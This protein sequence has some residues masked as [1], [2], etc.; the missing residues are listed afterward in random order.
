M[1]VDP[2]D[3][4]GE[5]L[6]QPAAQMRN[7]VNAENQCPFINSTC[8][9][10]S[11][12]MTGPFPVCSVFQWHGR[13]HEGKPE[14]SDIVCVCPKRL[15]AIDLLGD[16]IANCWP[17][18]PPANP[19]LV[20]EVKMGAGKGHIGN[21]DCVVADV[22]DN[23][24]VKEF[25][26]VELQAVD[27]TGSYL[28][29]YNALVNSETLDKKPAYGF[30]QAN[31]YKRFI[32]QLIAKGYYHSHWKTKIVAV[33]QDVVFNNMEQRTPFMKAESAKDA[34]ANIVFMVYKFSKNL[35]DRGEYIMELDRV[36]GTGH[37]NLQSAIL[38]KTPPSK[39]EFCQR[40]E[41]KLN[42]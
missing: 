23:G 42:G 41:S 33:I 13:A 4:I 8:M 16:V 30:N 10:R 24:N 6:G 27:I 18:T 39:E 25:I 20:H 40:I 31:V 36:V 7:P 21:V 3:I 5:V 35:N 1:P 11:Q 12:G 29:A 9:K 2:L 26:S 38:Y 34:N 32:T 14:K 19:R 37:A 15:F 17:G 28:P 22:A